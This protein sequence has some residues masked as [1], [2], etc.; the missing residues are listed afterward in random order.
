MKTTDNYKI[1]DRVQNIATG[2]TGTIDDFLIDDEGK[3]TYI[4][5]YDEMQRRPD[6]F[7]Y[8]NE[9]VFAEEIELA[10][11]FIAGKKYRCIQDVKMKK[12]GEV[13]FKAGNI[14]EQAND[15]TKWC[16]WLRNE[17]GER[18][19]WPQPVYIADTV[20]TWGSKPEDI[21]PRR[22]FEPV[23]DIREA[24]EA[25]KEREA[26]TLEP[27]S[28]ITA[29][30]EQGIKVGTEVWTTIE[31]HEEYGKR[32]KVVRK[33][34]ADH[35]VWCLDI[36]FEDGTTACYA[37]EYV[38]TE[39]PWAVVGAKCRH[40]YL[41]SDAVLTITAVGQYYGIEAESE[42][43]KVK[44]CGLVRDFEP[45]EIATEAEGVKVGDKVRHNKH[46]EVATVTAIRE[47]FVNGCDGYR[48]LYTLDFGQSVK[49][50]FDVELNG[51][52]FL[53]EAFTICEPTGKPKP[54]EIVA[55]VTEADKSASW[56]TSYTA[57]DFQKL[58]TA[59]E[60]NEE[61]RDIIG[62]RFCHAIGNDGDM[63]EVFVGDYAGNERHA[64]VYTLDPL[65]EDVRCKVRSLDFL[66][67]FYTE[68]RGWQAA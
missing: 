26:A 60:V 52:E 1:G 10:P 14:Y 43:G 18:H 9:E 59:G 49:G 35:G 21:D 53:R 40:K 56:E 44:R 32:G 23:V 15:P 54:V 46:E 31:L 57:D 4:V 33:F 24:K 64:L 47:A 27:A 8:Q 42:G 22:Y 19:G 58:T 50:P 38:T 36:E 20:K 29:S 11:F 68:A 48:Y 12:G 55:P 13:A 37:E 6:S 65:F 39:K 63:L 61:D 30:S 45:V 66:R 16:G 67:K 62:R 5:K 3:R 28:E 41:D 51:G 7:E 34:F 17:Q 25:A 2:A